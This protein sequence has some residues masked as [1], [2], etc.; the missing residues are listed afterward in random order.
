[1]ESIRITI[2]GS[3]ARIEGYPD[4]VK[5]IKVTGPSCRKLADLSLHDADLQFTLESLD[6]LDEKGAT[7][8]V[9]ESLWRSAI[10]HFFKCFQHSAS[11]QLLDAKIVYDSDPPELMKN[12]ALL[13]NLRNKHLVHDENSYAQCDVGAILNNGKKKLKI[14]RVF[15]VNLFMATLNPDHVQQ[16]RSMAHHALAY[17]RREMDMLIERITQDLETKKYDE[18]FAMP[19]LTQTSPT[20]DAVAKPR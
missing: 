4:T 18:L 6:A 15:S 13:K 10:V 17:V 1:M 14:E 5:V 11:R 16:L 20:V 8:H 9:R 19:S 3:V 7:A 12:F 2:T